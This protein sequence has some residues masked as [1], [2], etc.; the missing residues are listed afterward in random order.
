MK[1]GPGLADSKDR[2]GS[3][4]LL[5]PGELEGCRVESAGGCERVWWYLGHGGAD[6]S[7]GHFVVAETLDKAAPRS[8]CSRQHNFLR[9]LEEP[10]W[11][12]VQNG[13]CGLGELGR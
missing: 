2:E 12:C 10:S 4:R 13:L 7:G 1:T 3:S 5:S 11:G 8:F 9:V 6:Q